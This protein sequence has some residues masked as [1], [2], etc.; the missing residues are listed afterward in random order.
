MRRLYLI[1]LVFIL[2]STFLNFANAAEI[3]DRNKTVWTMVTVSKNNKIEGYIFGSMHSGAPNFKGLPDYVLAA[4]NASKI[5]VIESIPT[6]ESTLEGVKALTQS[7]GAVKLSEIFNEEQL[8]GIEAKIKTG[9]GRTIA[10]RTLLRTHPQT[11]IDFF[12]RDCYKLV[13]SGTSLDA[14]VIGY[15]QAYGKDVVPLESGVSQIGYLSKITLAD[16]R[17]FIYSAIEFGTSKNCEASTKAHMDELIRTVK[18]GD[19]DA[20]HKNDIAFFNGVI[21]VGGLMQATIFDRNKDLSQK[22]STLAASEKVP[23]FVALGASH[24]GGEQGVVALLKKQGFQV[25]PHS[26]RDK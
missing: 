22:I 18:L 4:I 12:L 9:F 3:E 24:L 6:P 2:F 19:F 11:L 13:A 7:L 10:K 26:A 15:A 23:F 16:W 1:V 17:K 20:L 8:S 21:G 5:I 25:A 14:V